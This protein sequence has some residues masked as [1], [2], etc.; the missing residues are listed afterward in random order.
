VFDV[1]S[2]P[3]FLREGSAVEDFLRLNRVVIGADSPQAIAILQDLYRPLYLIETPFVITSI[4][5]AE[6]IKYVSNSFLALKISFINELANLCEAL[7]VDVHVLAKAMGLD[8]RIWSEVFASGTGI[9]WFLLSQR[10]LSPSPHREGTRIVMRLN[11]QRIAHVITESGPFGGAQRNTLLT[12]KGLVQDGYEAELICGSGGPLIEE[13]KALGISVRVIPDLVRQVNPLKDCRA[14]IALTRLFRSRRH[15][16]VHT[17]STKAGLLGRLAAWFVRIPVIVHTVHGVPFEINGDVRS[18]IYIFLERFVGRITDRLICVGEVVRQEVSYWKIAP[19]EKLITIYSG[20]DFSL[21]NPRRTLGEIKSELGL[22]DSWPIVGSVGRLSEQK[23]QYYLIEAIALLKP[24]YPKIKLLLIGEGE[25]RPFLEKRIQDLDLSL[26]VS[27]LGERGDIAD[28]LSVFDVYGMSSRWE[29]VGRALTEA[30]YRGL[31]IVATAVNG[32]K[33]LIV[34]EETGLLVLPRDPN[35]LAFAIERLVGD[36]D[37]SQRLRVRAR[38]KAEELMDGKRMIADI[39]ELYAR[40]S[41]TSFS[42]YSS[43]PEKQLSRQAGK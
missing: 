4:E 30:M 3:E 31:P 5:A 21:Y 10:Y 11:P 1:A 14:F 2:N 20:I 35:A 36:S 17:H 26:N 38:R 16:I 32:V 25:L 7:G 6:L 13:A 28:L 18:R 12:L 23:A 15:K 22:R 19:N 33:E 24:T 40:L 29:G 43:L 27:L 41:D 9:W 39:K 37:L 8:Q 34:H 42:H